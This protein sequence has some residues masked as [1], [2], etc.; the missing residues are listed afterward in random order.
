MFMR[1]YKNTKWAGL[2]LVFIVA[3]TVT[4]FFSHKDSLPQ[5]TQNTTNAHCAYR[6]ILPDPICTPGAADPRVTQDNIQQT[7]CVSGYT[8]TV[9][10]S[11]SYTDNLKK[12]QMLEYGDTDSPSNYE[13][14]HLIPLEVGGNPT[15]PKN[16]WPEPRTGSPNASDKDGFENYLHRQVCDGQM[17][18]QEAQREAATGWSIFWLQSGSPK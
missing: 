16:L 1:K 6:T 17:T 13:E 4:L 18:L 8:K 7:I 15:D 14:D 3:V 11:V 10:P 2:A 9:R 12:Q 5:L